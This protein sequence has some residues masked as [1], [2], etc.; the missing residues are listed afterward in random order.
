MY[1]GSWNWRSRRKIRDKRWESRV[2]LCSRIIQQDSSKYRVYNVKRHRGN[3]IRDHAG[4]VVPRRCFK[5]DKVLDKPLLVGTISK[6]V[7]L[8]LSISHK[9][10]KL[11]GI[12]QTSKSRE[13]GPKLW[14]RLREGLPTDE[15]LSPKEN[16]SQ[17][18][19]SPSQSTPK[20]SFPSYSRNIFKTLS[21]SFFL[22]LL[23]IILYYSH[24]HS[25]PLAD[26]KKKKKTTLTA[27]QI[28]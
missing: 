25:I 3:G 4:E 7:S 18:L 10:R 23:L 26:Q 9:T 2:K 12:Q 1:R 15:W 20:N 8:S 16:Y 11:R 24:G 22:L 21:F 19:L 6:G 27:K 13:L 28:R 5:F 17:L 14:I